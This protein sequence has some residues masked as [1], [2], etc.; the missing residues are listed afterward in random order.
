MGTETSHTGVQVATIVVDDI[1]SEGL[2]KLRHAKPKHGLKNS[3]RDG[4]QRPT[5]NSDTQMLSYV[6]YDEIQLGVISKGLCLI[7]L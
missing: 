1:Q 4:L 3:H 6:R 5:D 7:V 2:S